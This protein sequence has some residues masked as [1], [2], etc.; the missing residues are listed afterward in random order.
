[1]IKNDTPTEK[2]YNHISGINYPYIV[3]YIQNTVGNS[4][5]ILNELERY[6][7]LNKVPIIEKEMR[8]L[9][10]TYLEITKPF[11]VVEIGTAI[12]YSAILFAQYLKNGGEVITLEKDE[13]MCALAVENINKA[14]CA[15]KIKII[16][17]DALETV[18]NIDKPID[19][20]FL[21]ANKSH[22]GEY[23]DALFPHLNVGGMII[24][25]NILYKG[26]VAS[27]DLLPRKHYTIVRAL[28]KF[29]PFLCE[30]KSLKTSIIPISDGVSVSVRIN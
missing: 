16:C 13:K 27:D 4:Q 2:N 9:L 15:D 22:Y 21:D 24:C 20:I 29:L 14:H 10:E 3:D 7:D 28:R 8:A 1:M 18:Y 5:G 17:G 26:M 30:N 6:A 19:F 12:G 23:F 25:D 11:R